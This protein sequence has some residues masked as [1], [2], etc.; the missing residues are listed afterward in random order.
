MSEVSRYTPAIPPLSTVKDADVRRVLEALVSGWRTRNGDIKPDSDERFITKGELQSLV[1][2]VN[3]GYFA[4]DAPGAQLVKDLAKNNSQDVLAL[5]QRVTDSVLTSRLFS[6]LGE[7]VRLIDLRL[8]DEQ[9]QRVLA[10]QQVATDLAAVAATQLGF[11]GT[12]GSKINSLTSITDTQATQISGL[13]TRVSGA[14]STIISLQTTTATSATQLSSL[15]TKVGDA[16][17]SI[18]VLNE[19]TATQ[20][21]ALNSLTTRVGGAESSISTLNTTTAN[22]ANSLTLLRSDVNSNTAAISQEA[23]TRANADNSITQTVNTQLSQVNQSVAALQTTQTT[24]S[25]NV[26]SLSNTVTT[27]QASVGDNTAAISSE[28]SARVT[29]DGRIE[30]KYTVK[31]DVNGYVSG[32]GLIG[33]ANDSAPFSDFLVRADRFA[34]ASP[35]GPGI[36]PKVPFVVYTT[37]STGLDGGY[38]PPGVYIDTAVIRDASIVRAKIG[39]AE[40]DTL[41]LAGGSVTSMTYALGEGYIGLNPGEEV[42]CCSAALNM[43]SG[44]S[45]VVVTVTCGM[46]GI[47]RSGSGATNIMKV[48]RN[49]A[50]LPPGGLS[51]SV[52]NGWTYSFT[53]AFFDAAPLEGVNTYVFQIANNTDSR[54]PGAFRSSFI[55]NPTITLTGG[56]R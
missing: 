15:T 14:E 1:E 10:V 6:E 38:I 43:P 52:L 54:D 23:T 44:S 35:A 36:A 19:T 39:L 12:I 24:L 53:T 50:V 9:T 31:V 30:S 33:T 25:N 5:L 41:R 28:A 29:A 40:I 20:A 16:E 46:Q 3:A 42:F 8:V 51:V 56:K 49:G 26:S 55:N 22:Q 7:R 34:I 13:T 21:Q 32:Y 4:A 27:L 45:G 17:S 18:S 37:P 47:G 2:S 48:Y 11:D